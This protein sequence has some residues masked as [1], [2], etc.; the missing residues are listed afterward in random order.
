MS[1]GEFHGT[2]YCLPAC[3]PLRVNVLLNRKEIRC[4]GFKSLQ[5]SLE[6]R[7]GCQTQGQIQERLAELSFQVEASSLGFCLRKRQFEALS[8]S[9]AATAD[10]RS[11]FY[12]F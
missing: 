5:L 9:K 1:A 7:D 3:S 4:D 6:L 8:T 12:S 10:K 11:H 2:G